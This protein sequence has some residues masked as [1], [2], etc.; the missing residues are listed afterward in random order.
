[1]GLTGSH[2]IDAVDTP[3]ERLIAGARR[4]AW[5]APER[6]ANIVT[7]LFLPESPRLSDRQRATMTQ[8]L[9][10]LIA[11]IE[12]D[13]RQRLLVTLSPDTPAELSASLAAGRLAI[14]APILDRAGLL[15][16]PELVRVLL[17]RA[18]EHRLVTALHLTAIAEQEA[19]QATEPG[20]VDE[21]LQTPDAELA[22]AV[23]ALLIAESRRF[24]RFQDPLLART[25]LAAELQHALVWRVAAA[26]RAYIVE[27]Q[28]A[29][30]ALADRAIAAATS[31][32]LAGYDEGATLEARAMVLARHLHLLGTLTDKLVLRAAKEGRVTLLAA[33]L[34]VRAGIDFDAAWDMLSDGEGHRLTVLLRAIDMDRSNAAELLFRL[35]SVAARPDAGDEVVAQLEAFEALSPDHAREEVLPWRMAEG[36]RRAIAELDAGR[37]V[38]R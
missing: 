16:D 22:A 26:L 4:A 13:L 24:D 11:A 35:A 21:L 36:Y 14:A 17:R 1:M 10:K 38:R 2:D 32:V 20:L 7:D 23:M 31:G 5:G 15:R 27:E 34:A 37:A 30:P 12:D 8:L 28:R 18:E 3:A 33:A 9:A 19:E 29:D 25:D 6:L